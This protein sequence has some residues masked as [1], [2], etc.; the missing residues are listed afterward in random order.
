MI[1][2]YLL[3]VADVRPRLSSTLKMTGVAVTAGNAI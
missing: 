2:Y 3:F 1:K